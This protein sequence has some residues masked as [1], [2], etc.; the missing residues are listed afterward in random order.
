MN[1]Q[2]SQSRFRLCNLQISFSDFDIK[3]CIGAGSFG[4]VFSCYDKVNEREVALKVIDTTYMNETK[5][6]MNFMR[7]ILVPIRLRI[8]GIVQTYGFKFPD[9]SFNEGDGAKRYMNVTVPGVHRKTK[10]VDLTGPMISTEIMRNGSLD[11]LLPKYFKNLG[12]G[13][14][15]NPTNRTKIMFGV[16]ATMKKIHQLD[17]IHRDLK[18]ANVFLDDNL[19]P[20][21]ADFGL[22]KEFIDTRN[23][24]NVGTPFAMAPEIFMGTEYDKSVDV[25]AFGFFM[26]NMFT[27]DIQFEVGTPRSVHQYMSFITKGQRPI[28]KPNIPEVYWQLITKCWSESPAERPSFV[29]VVEIMKDD[30]FALTEYDQTTDLNQLHEYQARIDAPMPEDFEEESRVITKKGRKTEFVWT[31]Q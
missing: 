18:V 19:E 10:K 17:L 21:I 24:L 14:K 25:Y 15:L 28:K 29:E 13:S 26:Y 5:K 20:Q 6:L 12:E 2:R 4:T 3:K 23:T 8:P 16:A 22:A 27:T 31:R 1:L 30:S 9:T 11:V 7:E